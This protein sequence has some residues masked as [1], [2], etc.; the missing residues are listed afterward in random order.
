MLEM[1]SDGARF[2]S[3]LRKFAFQSYRGASLPPVTAPPG[4][5]LPENGWPRLSSRPDHSS[6]L[7][8]DI[9]AV[10]IGR[11]LVSHNSTAHF[12]LGL[13]GQVTFADST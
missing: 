9:K 4:V 11:Q 5:E 8:A 13:T 7:F 3:C 6:L 10:C 12:Q 2:S 1:P